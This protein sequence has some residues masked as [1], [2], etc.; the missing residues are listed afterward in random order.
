MKPV[1][2]DTHCH[3]Q[4][5]RLQPDLDAVMTRAYAAGV[6]RFVCC[7]TREEDWETVLALAKRYDGVIPA[8]GLHPWF[9]DGRSE[10]WLERLESLVAGNPCAVGEIGLDHAL[11][12]F[13]RNGQN[14][15][16][17][18]QVRLAW[19]YN[20][21]VS[22]HCRKAWGALERALKKEGGLPCEGVVHSFSGYPDMARI[23]AAYRCRFSW[24]GSITRSFN[25]RGRLTLA[26]VPK[27]T[28]VLE[29]D[30]PDIMPAGPAGTVNEPAN[31]TYTAG[32][33][34]ENLG[35]TVEEI[36][37][38]TTNNAQR[39]FGPVWR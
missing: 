34:A 10:R 3:L 6:T 15:V 39:S 2:T 17:A 30:C 29:T 28:I 8:L 25:K 7:G 18:A 27:E 5:P 31:I 26:S 35:M 21:P 24:S 12:R 32:A 11:E 23:C 20:R 9:V 37:S 36:A 19:K 16:F 14:D 33:V 4:D 1:F 22:I 38:L 13:D